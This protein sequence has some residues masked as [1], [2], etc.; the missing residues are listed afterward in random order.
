MLKKQKT[1]LPSKPINARA[2]LAPYFPEE[3]DMRFFNQLERIQKFMIV[4]TTPEVLQA[5][6]VAAHL[7]DSLSD[8]SI[9]KLELA[10]M[11]PF[12]TSV[13]VTTEEQ[14]LFAY[15]LRMKADMPL[16]QFLPA[17]KEIMHRL[18]LKAAMT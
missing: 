17:G 11:E 4:D 15:N 2:F 13:L 8:K 3:T 16:F 6:G 9:T 1:V 12:F 10:L 14:E 18:I 5:W 7:R